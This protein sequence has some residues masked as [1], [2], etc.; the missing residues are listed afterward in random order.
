MSSVILNRPHFLLSSLR[1]GLSVAQFLLLRRAP[2]FAYKTPSFS[3]G[4]SLNPPSFQPQGSQSTRS[5][6]IPTYVAGGPALREGG[7]SVRNVPQ[8]HMCL[9]TP[10]P[11]AWPWHSLYLVLSH[12]RQIP[13]LI[14]LSYIPLLIHIQAWS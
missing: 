10:G 3:I 9:L 11:L 12:H 6:H 7:G 14:I 4:I 1:D 5:T 8:T 13:R 2:K